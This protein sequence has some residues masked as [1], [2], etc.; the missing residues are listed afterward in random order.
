[1]NRAIYVISRLYTNLALRNPVTFFA[2]GGMIA[3]SLLTSM[4]DIAILHHNRVQLNVPEVVFSIFNNQRY[5]TY[6]LFF[7]F[8]F[9][10]FPMFYAKDL[11]R[12]IAGRTFCRSDFWTA[13]VLAIVQI[14]FI[15]LGIAFLIVLTSAML[16][17]P[18]SLEWSDAYGQ[19]IREY[20]EMVGLC[21]FAYLYR[22]YNPLSVAILQA[23]LFL[24]SFIFVGVLSAVLVQIIERQMIAFIAVSL[25]WIVALVGYMAPPTLV[26]LSPATHLLLNGRSPEFPF[27]VS[28]FYLVSVLA[29]LAIFG[30]LRAQKAVLGV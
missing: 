24:I 6:G 14:A 29:L 15:Y 3:Y 2:M 1:M 28:F 5:T 12:L 13:R 18:F 11:E 19:Y 10:I 23:L 20:T 16:N 8:L 22:E 30:S 21:G 25:Y 9:I 17:F 26:F 27:I 7:P 4:D